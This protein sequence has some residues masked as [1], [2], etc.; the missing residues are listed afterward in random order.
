MKHIFVPRDLLMELLITFVPNPKVSEEFTKRGSTAFKQ[1]E[2]LLHQPELTGGENDAVAWLVYYA[3]DGVYHTT[4][5]DAAVAMRYMSMAY[6]VHPLFRA[7]NRSDVFELQRKL[8]T[9]TADRDAE[10]AMKA[11]A[12]EQRD[13]MV[14]KYNALHDLKLPHYL[15]LSDD[16]RAAGE[17]AVSD[18]KRGG[19]ASKPVLESVYFEAAIQLWLND[20]EELLERHETQQNATRTKLNE[21]LALLQRTAKLN[22]DVSRCGLMEGGE[23]YPN[24]LCTTEMANDVEWFLKQFYPDPKK[25]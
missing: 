6:N 9:M 10:K 21:A 1:I 2:K 17:E 24:S 11:T 16:M 12:R 20:Q 23:Q 3:D 4:T 25:G 8:E 22:R 19:C 13:K 15:K 18:A 5:R 14:A 7:A